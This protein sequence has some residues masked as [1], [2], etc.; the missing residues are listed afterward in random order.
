MSLRFM[1]VSSF[2][3]PDSYNFFKFSENTPKYIV[4]RLLKSL[5]FFSPIL[6]FIA[7]KSFKALTSEYPSIPVYGSNPFLA[8]LSLIATIRLAYMISSSVSRSF[9]LS[10]L[11]ISASAFL[12]L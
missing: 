12:N 7:S 9:L 10:P 8:L 4:A 11:Y 3:L 5:N 2:I 1:Y 6:F